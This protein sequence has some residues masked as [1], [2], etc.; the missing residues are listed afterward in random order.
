LAYASLAEK[1][2]PEI[3][4]AHSAVFRNISPGDSRLT[5]LADQ[6]GMTK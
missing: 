2:F 4:P 1:G 3:R 5:D 6:A